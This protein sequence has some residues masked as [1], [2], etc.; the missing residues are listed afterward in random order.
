MPT[1]VFPDVRQSAAFDCG[2]AAV[3]GVLHY[4][5]E[6]HDEADIVQALGTTPED[7]TQVGRIAGYLVEQGF[8]ILA[9]RM[10]IR[11]LEGWVDLKVPVIL[12]IQA[13]AEV[14]N[15]DYTKS[16]EY[17]HY[18]VCVGYDA[19]FI[20]LEDPGLLGNLGRLSRPQ[21]EARWHGLREGTLLEHFG[22]A[23]YGRKPQYDPHEI[24]TIQARR[25]ANAWLANRR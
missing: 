17:G 15:V 21:L 19:D 20:Y 13:W 5:G 2:A 3:Q 25:V 10:S 14:D 7:G 22:I 24:R 12:D 16:V 23:V 6:V 8:S 1:I 18:V 11:D 4:Y 9:G